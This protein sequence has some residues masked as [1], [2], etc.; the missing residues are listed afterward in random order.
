M[1]EYISFNIVGIYF[2]TLYIL[3]LLYLISNTI[4]IFSKIFVLFHPITRP[5][6]PTE[7]S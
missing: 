7:E 4:K 2:Y 6:P 3:H 1:I 5:M